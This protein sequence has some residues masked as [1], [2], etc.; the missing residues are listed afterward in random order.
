MFT[1]EQHLDNLTRHIGLVR[2]ACLLL[3]KRLIAAGRKDFGRLVIM[4]GFMHDV[5]KFTGIEW[6]YLHVGP[7]VDKACLDL[8]I[9]QHSYT[10]SHH[11]EFHGGV[12]NMPELD[13]AEM[14]CDWYARGQEF[15]TNLREWIRDVAVTRFRIGHLSDQEG[16]ITQ[17]TNLLLENAFK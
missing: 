12:K 3:G 1:H 15:G 5:T 6:D 9:K 16:W 13:V 7:D 8:A 11:P 17:F 2:E 10:N 4:R 14:V